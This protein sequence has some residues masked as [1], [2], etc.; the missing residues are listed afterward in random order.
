MITKVCS[1]IEMFFSNCSICLWKLDHLKIW[2]KKNGC[3]SI[4]TLEEIN[5]VT[6][7]ANNTEI[8]SRLL[9]RKII[10]L[11]LKNVFSQKWVLLEKNLIFRKIEVYTCVWVYLFYIA[12]L[13][14]ILTRL[15]ILISFLLGSICAAHALNI[16]SFNQNSLF[17]YIFPNY[18][19]VIS[20]V[21]GYLNANSLVINKCNKPISWISEKL[22]TIEKEVDR[23]KKW[24]NNVTNHP[25]MS[26]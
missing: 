16:L 26:L 2:I 19:G 9:S 8:K 5:E 20:C 10:K 25:S 17:V 3:L 24:L 22:K 23:K 15:Q 21:F 11:N 7:R 18:S 14:F 6:E 12:I 4:V 13:K 1:V